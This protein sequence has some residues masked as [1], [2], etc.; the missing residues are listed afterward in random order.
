MAVAAVIGLFVSVMVLGIV[1]WVVVEMSKEAKVDTSGEMR[2]P[3]GKAVMVAPSNMEVDAN[4][5]LKPRGTTKSMVTAPK[6]LKVGMV[7]RRRRLRSLQA[8]ELLSVL[9]VTGDYCFAY[10]TGNEIP[11]AAVM[12]LRESCLRNGSCKAD[13]VFQQNGDASK[14][15]NSEM[16]LSRFNPSETRA[17][18]VTFDSLLKS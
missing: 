11:A 16:T 9:S 17:M 6:S 15:I 3:A 8:T 13:A 7:Q 1:V 4:G 5:E 2:T 18:S 14:L 12:A 10:D